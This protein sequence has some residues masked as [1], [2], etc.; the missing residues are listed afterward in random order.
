MTIARALTASAQNIPPPRT[1]GRHDGIDQL[2][3]D[4]ADPVGVLRDDGAVAAGVPD[5]P[6]VQAEADRGWIGELEEARDTVLA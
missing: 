2:E 3:V 1:P 5:V 6:G 4:V